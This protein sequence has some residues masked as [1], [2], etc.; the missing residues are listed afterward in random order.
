LIVP[1]PVT[2]IYVGIVSLGGYPVIGDVLRAAQLTRE[3]RASDA[4]LRDS[5]ARINLAADAANFGLW[6]WNIRDD[7]LLV[8]EKW[9]KLFGFAEWERVKLSQLL[10]IVHPEDRG[11]MK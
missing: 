8:T 10:M 4:S 3:L 6:V 7:E 2:F 11:R 1:C 9:R 5:E